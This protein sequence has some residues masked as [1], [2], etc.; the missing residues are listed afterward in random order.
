[1]WKLLY[2][3]FRPH[4]KFPFKLHE[5]LSTHHNLLII[6]LVYVAFFFLPQTWMWCVS[7]ADL[8]TGDYTYRPPFSSSYSSSSF[9]F[10]LLD[11]FGEV[12]CIRDSRAAWPTSWT[13]TGERS[14]GWVRHTFGF[15]DEVG[16]EA[17]VVDGACGSG[18]AGVHVWRSGERLAGWLRSCTLFSLKRC[19]RPPRRVFFRL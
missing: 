8:S 6:S 5:R 14:F 1:M 13:W 18:W 17:I 15:G 2:P 12:L 4:Q 7:G 11:N 9:S 10:E 16:N 19:L 3:V